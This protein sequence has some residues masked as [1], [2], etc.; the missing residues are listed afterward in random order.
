M[1]RVIAKHQAAALDL[2]PVGVPERMLFEARDV[3]ADATGEG[4]VFGF[5]NAQVSVLAPT[6]TIA[7]MM[8]CDTTGVEPDIALIKYKKMVG[9]GYIKIV[10]QTVPAALR[11]LGYEAAQVEEILAYI[12]ERETIE[13]APH[14][15]AEHLPVFDCAFKPVNGERSIHHMGHIK[16]MGAIQP[17]I[18]GAISKT[19]NLPSHATEDD[20]ENV[21]LEGWKLG[22]KAVAVYRDG[23]KRSQPL[24]AGKTVDD[25]TLTLVEDLRKQLDAALIEAS[26]PKRR[27]LPVERAAL[28]HKFN[29]S[30]QEGYV[31][32]GLY[33]DGQPGEI[34]LTMAKE[35]ST[36]SGLMDAFATAVSLSL[37]YGVPLRDLVNKFSHV[38]FDPQG[39]TGN[40]EVPIAKSIIDYLFRWLGS[41]FLPA[42]DRER[43]GIQS[44]PDSPVFVAP[45]LVREPVAEEAPRTLMSSSFD[46]RYGFAKGNDAEAFISTNGNGH[47]GD[48]PFTMG[49]MLMGGFQNQEDAPSCSDCGSMTVRSGSCYKCL[50]CGSTTG[51]S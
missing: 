42:E 9:E 21:Y 5:R 44:A 30:G 1:L 14:I 3:W 37:Q 43:L 6:G 45:S 40:P 28:T 27:R 47:S 18:S 8:D 17:F 51:C 31:T 24:N 4:S 7:F 26:K 22:L 33:E 49:Q 20:I 2:L 16:M 39:F 48:S 23:S 34:F 13:G 38:R 29:I 46:D 41:R 36:V 15:K 25:G 12:E 50:N 11:K 32:V 10:N 19:V 35:G